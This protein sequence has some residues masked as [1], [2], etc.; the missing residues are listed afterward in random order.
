MSNIEGVVREDIHLLLTICAFIGCIGTLIHGRT[1]HNSR[2][3]R[4][5][6]SSDL[7]TGTQDHLYQM[8]P[9]GC[10]LIRN[11]PNI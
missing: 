11:P 7:R 10:T 9:T 1:D 4:I 2:T 5:S 3:P 8:A 6:R